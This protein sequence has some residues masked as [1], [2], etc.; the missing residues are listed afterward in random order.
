[1]EEYLI[2]KGNDGNVS[3]VVEKLFT[4][5]MSIIEDI[6]KSDAHKIA[7]NIDMDKRLSRIERFF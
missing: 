7:I 6:Q 3:V 1:M 5:I 2:A 4:S